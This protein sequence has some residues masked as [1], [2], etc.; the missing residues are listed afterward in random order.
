MSPRGGQGWA[1]L[2]WELMR[3]VLI[4]FD[5]RVTHRG[6][7]PGTP[8]SQAC[9]C[10]HSVGWRDSDFNKN[11]ST[12]CYHLPPF[13]HNDCLDKKY[14]PCRENILHHGRKLEIFD[15]R[16]GYFLL[17]KSTQFMPPQLSP[18]VWEIRSDVFIHTERFNNIEI[19][20]N[21]LKFFL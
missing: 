18:E 6:S 16:A 11:D 2:D 21:F 7:D 9:S 3:H 4:L 19:S 14:V 12:S 13:R 8:L 20:S 17:V 5:T 1:G 15:G 10:L